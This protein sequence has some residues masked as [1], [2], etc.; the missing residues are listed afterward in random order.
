MRIRLG[1]ILVTVACLAGCSRGGESN[2][3]PRAATTPS[4]K[5]PSVHRMSLTIPSDLELIDPPWTLAVSARGEIAFPVKN[6]DDPVFATIDSNGAQMGTIAKRGEG[7]HES[8]GAGGNLF[9]GDSTALML[10]PE[11]RQALVFGFDGTPL[12]DERNVASYVAVARNGESVLINRDFREHAKSYIESLSLRNGDKERVIAPTDSLL[13]LLGQSARGRWPAGAWDGTRI[14]LGEGYTYTLALYQPGKSPTRFGRTLPP[15]HRTDRELAEATAELERNNRLPFIGPDGRASNGPPLEPQLRRL[16]LDTLPYFN[17]AG[18]LAFDDSGRLWVIGQTN[19]STFADVYAD[20]TLIGRLM[21]DC[22]EPN[23]TR[24][25]A[26]HA[27]WLA[28]ACL[29]PDDFYRLRLY[30]IEG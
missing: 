15:R 21:I 29:D 22:R 9:S 27:H 6:L 19:N 30:R 20:T 24:P 1:V 26:L 10:D 28:M 3:P 25:V 4:T 13:R 12:I 5:M 11:S 14:V 17:D 18:G 2:A 16:P 8:V 23:F 7:P